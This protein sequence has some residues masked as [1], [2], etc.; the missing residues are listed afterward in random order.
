M[1]GLLLKYGLI[2]VFIGGALEGDVTFVIAGVTTHLG[3]LNLATAIMVGTL[4]A[5][6]GDSTLYWLG[7]S[8]SRQIRN[9]KAYQR[10][11]PIAS[12]LASRLGPWEIL[13]A[14]FVYGARIA[15]I[16]FWSTRKLSFVKFAAVD[17]I[18]CFI[19]CSLLMTLGRLL[20]HRATIL[21]GEVRRVELLLLAVVIVIVTI[22]FVL[23]T[24]FRRSVLKTN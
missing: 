8:R 1:G 24:I 19:W 15:S 22:S 5:L 16:I 2:A 12:R 23:K 11:E 17:L 13:V 10:A 3:F 4:G 14:R 21:I 18:G 9:T 7:R 20:S 6:T